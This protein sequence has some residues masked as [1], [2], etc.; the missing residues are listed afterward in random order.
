MLEQYPEEQGCLDSYHA[1]FSRRTK[2]QGFR[3]QP[4]VADLEGTTKLGAQLAIAIK[5]HTISRTNQRKHAKTQ[6]E[7]MRKNT[8][9][10]ADIKYKRMITKLRYA[11]SDEAASVLLSVTPTEVRSIRENLASDFTFNR[12]NGETM[13]DRVGYIWEVEPIV[14]APPDPLITELQKAIERMSVE[15]R[16]AL[17]QL[18]RE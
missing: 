6:G 13:P 15:D 14:V 17:A 10:S 9:L 4:F 8:G 5:A 2:K 12:I 1:F 16:K 18:V 3:G 11:P 7:A